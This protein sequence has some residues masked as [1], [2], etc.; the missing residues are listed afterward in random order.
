MTFLPQSAQKFRIGHE[1]S[2]RNSGIPAASFCALSGATNI[3]NSGR[4]V[5]G[6]LLCKI[7]VIRHRFWSVVTGADI[8]LN[9]QIGGGLLIPHPNGIVIHPDA[10]IGVNCLIFQQVTLGIRSRRVRR[11]YQVMST[12]AQA[13]KYWGHQD[14]GPCQN[15]RECGYTEERGCGNNGNRVRWLVRVSRVGTVSGHH[16]AW[17]KEPD[18]VRMLMP[19]PPKI[20]I[21]A[22][23]TAEPLLTSLTYVLQLAGLGLDVSFAPYN[24]VFQELLSN[25]SP[26][27]VNTNGV[28]LLLV[29]FEDFVR[30]VPDDHAAREIISRTTE[31]LSSA[32]SSH[33]ARARVP[34][35][36]AL[37]A[38]SPL[39]KASVSADLDF[40]RRQLNKH[41][42]SLPGV[43]LVSSEE[44]D[45]V[46]EGERYDRVSDELG[47]IPFTYQ[48]FSSLA[49]SIARKIHAV[50]TPAQKV[51]VLDCDNTLWRG[52]VGEDGLD[53][54]EI[55]PAF[56][57]IQQFAIK[58]HAEGALICLVSKN[59]ER[60]VL[61]VFE[62][63]EDMLLRTD[64]IVAHRINWQTKPANIVS[65]AR[66]LN[67]GLKS[68]VFLDDNPVECA[69]MRTE[70]PQIIT[71]EL[72]PEDQVQSFI[73]QL[74][75]FD[76]IST[77]D[78][79]ARRTQMYKEDSARRESE[80]SAL[81][82][83]DFI[84]SLEVVIDIQPPNETDWPRLSQL[85][86]RTN[87][88]NFTT[89]RRTEP[90]LRSIAGDGFTVRCVSVRDRFGDYGLVGLVIVF[91]N[92][93]RLSVDTLLLSCR[94]LG[95]GVEHA[96][97][98]ELGNLAEKRNLSNVSVTFAPTAKNEPARAFLESV[99]SQF[100]L[101][102]G[103]QLR[104]IIP[105]NYG[106]LITHR[107]G[108]DPDAVIEASKPAANLG[109]ELIC[110]SITR[111][112]I[113]IPHW[114]N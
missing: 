104:Y 113:A 112:Q 60:D 5:V 47:H 67:L 108:E 13:Q 89:I 72:P 48:H 17:S 53:G 1:R 85:T 66:S 65:L 84:A 81:D 15:W 9:C 41:A 2:R 54:I 18:I 100:R 50:R 10:K 46:S 27:A 87:Q 20:E 28:N 96:I 19:T 103:E 29:R 38:S 43:T 32:L 111:D 101:Q 37:L 93:D 11:K 76:K 62:K 94:V 110:L 57:S 55:T 56:A 24:Q 86:Q 58:A 68:F 25:A 107:P 106:R 105:A 49:L 95:R 23:F 83:H 90:E 88:F 16:L 35:V 45:L 21:A 102:E 36:V 80:K 71:L 59:V 82:I 92:S 91:N 7:L 114:R 40:A 61:E 12:S 98:S 99:V 3:G 97:L 44:I 70:L 109:Q 22:T 73:A 79:D 74:W 34:T 31:E 63:R 75:V 51:L 4:G 42:R 33:A 78:E 39:A 77:T 64:H 8:P 52:V 14:R 30:D 69:L 26:F 6:S